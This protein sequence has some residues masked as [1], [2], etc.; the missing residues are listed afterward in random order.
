MVKDATV[1]LLMRGSLGLWSHRRR[2]PIS[3]LRRGLSIFAS[4]KL[5]ACVL[6]VKIAFEEG[7][8]G[9]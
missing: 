7:C 6:A 4:F 9:V 1:A 5:V 2:L 3:L 8:D